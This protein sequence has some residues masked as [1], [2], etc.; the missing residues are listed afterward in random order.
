[1]QKN[2]NATTVHIVQAMAPGG[3]ETLVLDLAREPDANVRVFSFEGSREQLTAHW[4]ALAPIAH[5]IEGFGAGAGL[6]PYLI[7][8]LARRLRQLNAKSVFLHHVGPLIYGGLAARLAG[9]ERIIHVEHDVW[10]YAQPRRRMIASVI[11][12]IVR[13]HH[14]AVSAHAARV[15]R[16]MLPSPAVSVIHNGID[17]ERFRPG[18]KAIARAAFNLDPAWRIVG[19]AG[20]L[21]A[22]KGH[23]VLIRAAAALPVDCHVAIA[24]SGEEREALQ[25]LAVSLGLSGRIHFLG[26]VDAVEKVLPAFDVFCLP[27]HNEGFPR[28]IIEAQ[29]VGLPV[30]ATDVGA[31]AEAVC[32]LTGRIVPPGNPG[33][34][35][36]A[37]RDVLA[38]PPMI[39]P[40]EFVAD[41]FSWTQTLSSYRKVSELSHVA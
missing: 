1:M 13:P 7:V 21:V 4:P 25:A 17:L 15:L 39:P 23:E 9:V 16:S 37:L 8:Q 24:G 19:T 14:V 36:K 29:A 35:A 27:S 20:R 18:D 31:L 22:V 12:A 34:L 26:H 28:S 38:I 6:K 5:R 41:R 30:V 32:P 2:L 40:R 11:E 10:H 33:A 3:I